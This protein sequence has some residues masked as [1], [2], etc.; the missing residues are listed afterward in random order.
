MKKR[1][2]TAIL[3]CCMLLGTCSVA[4]AEEVS[5]DVNS[6]V[7]TDEVTSGSGIDLDGIEDDSKT[8]YNIVQE[9]SEEE[10]SENFEEFDEQYYGT[11]EKDM[12][13][14]DEEGNL[15]ILDQSEMGDGVIDV[16]MIATYADSD[17][18][19]NFRANKYGQAIP[20]NN[21]VEYTE[22]KTGNSGYINGIGGA[23][24]A[25]L[26]TENGKVK[27]MM[28]GVI[29]LVNENAVQVVSYDLVK[30]SSDYCSDGKY[31]YHR[32]STDMTTP[33]Y[34][35][36]INVGYKPSYL[37]TGVTYYSYDG[38][39]FYKDYKT[40]VSDYKTDTR[41][42]AVNA[43]NP[44]Y[45]YFQYLPLRSATNYTGSQL[46][47]MINSK[48]VSSSKMYNT[49]EIFVA[50]Q[51]QYGT[52]ALLIASI[53][54]IESA[55]GTSSISQSKNNLFGWNAVDATPSESADYFESP[56]A[57]IKEYTG[58]H[59][60]QGYLN[61]NYSTYHGGFLGNKASG[62]NV[63][64]ASD[65]YWG[66]KIAAIAWS[67][68]NANGTKDQNQYKL[69]IKDNVTYSHTNLNIRKE[70]STSS[71]PIY[72]TVSNA[73]YSF[74]ILGESNGFYKIQSDGIL[75]SSRTA[76][77]G[78]NGK[79]NATSMFAYA[80]KDYITVVN[81][82]IGGNSSSITGEITGGTT[83]EG[84]SGLIS[85]T[86]HVQKKGWT[87]SVADGKT[88]GTVGSSLRLEGIKVSLNNVGY[89]GSVEYKTHVQTYGWQDW[90][91]D[92]NLSGTS[93]ESKRLEAIRIRLTGDVAKQYDIYYRVHVQTYG[94]LDWAKN[95]ELAGSEGG[96][97][98]LEAIEIKL[99][100]KG[101]SAPG[102]TDTP[103]IQLLVQ[104]RS[105]VQTYGW[106]DYVTGGI[107]SGTSGLSKRLE[108]IQITTP[109]NTYAGNI[110]YRVHGQTYGWQDWRST[111]EIAGTFGLSKRLEAIQI[112]LT[113]NMAKNYDVYYRVHCQTYGWLDWAKNGETAG[114]VG[115]SKRLESIQIVLVEK[116]EAAPG[117]TDKPCVEK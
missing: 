25:Y 77:I 22:Y 50:T 68:D 19:V 99:V 16:P 14:I 113:G 90:V 102:E 2:I 8:N 85:Y 86:T 66:E 108:A 55:W 48:T 111:G 28:S 94:W 116:G 97:K 75:N 105:H 42:H 73:H 101:A 26:G 31:L 23:D 84:T 27:F 80:S 44:Y 45:N 65:P 34:I 62:M 41:S 52:N 95:G 72:Q 10:S 115:C 81:N 39:Y 100:K 12:V 117:N 54:A 40:M 9:K 74:I 87:S 51:N 106:Q 61:P 57:C 37:Q 32:I 107:L 88:S 21:C 96:S 63:S 47:Q 104:Y 7:L 83:N 36:E 56:S 112:R 11:E 24:A 49:G 35:A 70:A 60:S 4:Y 1:I 15:T 46:S 89:S 103:Y 58:M 18:I 110:E 43:V 109:V 92:G 13:M 82:G 69:G 78:N 3:S 30:S 6:V 67:L 91:S 98:R 114:T 38:H 64:Y 53:G 76:I 5:D 79:Y 71:R 93:G 33:G 17:K 20:T 29:G 59:I